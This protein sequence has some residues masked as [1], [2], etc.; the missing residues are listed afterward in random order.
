V[1]LTV[2]DQDSPEIWP[3]DVLKFLNEHYQLFL[4]WERRNASP[5]KY[6]KAIY[7]LESALAP[8]AIKGWHCTRLTETEIAS[9]LANGMQLPDR[10][11]LSRRIDAL[12]SEKLVTPAV[13]NVLKSKNQADEENRVGRVWFCFFP[14]RIAGESGIGDLLRHWGGEALYNSHDRD[15]KIGPVLRSIGVP[16]LVEANVPIASLGRNGGLSFKIVRRYLISR[17]HSSSEPVEHEDR[18]VCPLAAEFICRVIQFPEPDF[19]NLT[20]CE[21]WNDALR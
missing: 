17:D 8:H 15:Q 6:D 19:L 5:K 2:I 7:G 3:A 11:M 13:A 16:C 20:G 21:T 1:N 18:V 9:I 14:P 4:D 12:E 10:A